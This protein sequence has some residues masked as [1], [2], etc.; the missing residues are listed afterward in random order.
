MTSQSTHQNMEGVEQDLKKLMDGHVVPI[1]PDS[2]T[3]THSNG[4][5]EDDYVPIVKKTV[6]YIAMGLVFNEEGQMLLIQEAKQ[7][8]RGQWYIPAGR[9]EPGENFVDG[10]KREVKEEA[11][12]DIEV[13]TLC[14]LEICV[15]LLWYRI[16]CIARPKGGRLKT[17]AEQDE[18]SLQAQWFT[19]DQIRNKEM[20][21]RGTDFFKVMEMAQ[22]YLATPP[23][24]RHPAYQVGIQAHSDLLQRVV[25]IKHTEDGKVEILCRDK[26]QRCLPVLKLLTNIGSL[27]ISVGALLKDVFKTKMIHIPA[28]GLLTLEHCGIPAEE[29][30]GLCL[31]VVYVV[32]APLH[33]QL[34]TVQSTDYAWHV[35]ANDELVE[36]INLRMVAQ[37]L[38]IPIVH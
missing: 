10:V 13:I 25:I 8:I 24:C 37:N 38:L 34:K 36:K 33:E 30:D 6:S 17:L 16:C 15:S 18:E 4:L 5:W 29:H 20:K 12:I 14:T 31:T 1:H 23:E 21:L 3:V 19:L 9:I 11:G 28:T 27:Y 7:R 22:S 26:P 32:P 35:I 2:I